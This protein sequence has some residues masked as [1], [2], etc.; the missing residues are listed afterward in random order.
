MLSRLKARILLAEC[1]GRDIWPVDI[2]RDRGVPDTWID[3][4][5]DCFESGFERDLDTVYHA[6]APV[7]QFHSVQDLHLAYKL[8]ALLGVDTQQSTCLALGR[9]AEV[10][11]L[12]EAADEV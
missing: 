9:T 3:E 2:C 7:N 8:A 12:Q 4:L 10:R 1:T 11:A 6:D 5:A